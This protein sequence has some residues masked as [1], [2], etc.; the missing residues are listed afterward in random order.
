MLTLLGIVV[1]VAG[2][3][4]SSYPSSPHPQ[5]TLCQGVSGKH[6][7][8]VG[9]RRSAIVGHDQVLF[10]SARSFSTIIGI[11]PVLPRDLDGL[12]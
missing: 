4:A 12:I 10:T 5:V 2:V 7:V 6:V 8:D 1:G 11:P 9:S 3:I